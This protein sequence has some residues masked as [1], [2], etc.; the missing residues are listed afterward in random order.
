MKSALA[1]AYY[2]TTLFSIFTIE[3]FLR[4]MGLLFSVTIALSS[5]DNTK[6]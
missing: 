6:Q 1:R 2:A 5:S 4:M 3:Y